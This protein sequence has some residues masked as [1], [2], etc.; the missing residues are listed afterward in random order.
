VFVGGW[1]G[2]VEDK[3]ERKMSLRDN[4]WAWLLLLVKLPL[5]IF[6]PSC[7][8]RR[9]AKRALSWEALQML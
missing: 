5:I 3:D 4:V 7:L 6:R 1:V 9:I 2:I 8:S